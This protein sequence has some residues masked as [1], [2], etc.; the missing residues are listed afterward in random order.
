M[1]VIMLDRLYDSYYD[2]KLY[3][4]P[5]TLLCTYSHLL[6]GVQLKSPAP[7][8]YHKKRITIIPVLYVMVLIFVASDR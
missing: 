4:K 8:G 3:C 5:S 2:K 1:T 6:T 7:K